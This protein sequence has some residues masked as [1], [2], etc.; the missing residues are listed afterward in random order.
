M[1]SRLDILL[2][3]KNGS[4]DALV[5]GWNPSKILFKKNETG[6]QK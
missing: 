3:G 4:G 5:Q 2:G 1:L 6:E